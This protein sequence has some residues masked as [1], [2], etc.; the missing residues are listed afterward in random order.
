MSIERKPLIAFAVSAFSAIIGSMFGSLIYFFVIAVHRFSENNFFLGLTFASASFSL[1]AVIISGP[2]SI[3]IGIPSI[4]FSGDRFMRHP[5]I[6]FVILIAIGGLLGFLVEEIVF[7]GK[8][9]GLVC[10]VLGSSIAAF[11]VPFAYLAARRGSSFR[12]GDIRK[13][14]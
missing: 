2:V 4:Y 10:P 6:S 7:G 13:N 12:Q 1:F 5:W 8:F 11:H 9:I 3:M 14:G